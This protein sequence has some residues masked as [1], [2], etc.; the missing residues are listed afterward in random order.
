MFKFLFNFI[1]SFFYSVQ[2]IENENIRKYIRK[3]IQNKYFK[4]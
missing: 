1:L 2:M 3:Y 4:V